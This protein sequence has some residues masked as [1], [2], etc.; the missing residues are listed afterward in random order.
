VRVARSR[1]RIFARSRV[2]NFFLRTSGVGRHAAA[3]GRISV[4]MPTPKP[5]SPAELDR[6]AAALASDAFPEAMPLDA[7]QGMFYALASGPA[8]FPSAD[9]WLPPLLGAD[10]RWPDGDVRRDIEMLLKRFAAE[11]ERDIRESD[12]TLPLLLFD[13]EHGDP[14]Y[15]TWCRGYLD[16]VDASDPAWDT[17]A[18]R[19]AV[20]EMLLSIE[21]LAQERPAAAP[22]RDDIDDL[23]AYAREARGDIVGTLL[24][25]RHFWFDR[26]TSR[27]PVTRGTPKVGRNDP[28]PCGSGRKFKQCHGSA[29]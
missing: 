5:L 10:V 21:V 22:A 9:A 8:D 24:D 12:D 17:L 28:C 20:D 2:W 6:L 26:R 18:D 1:A 13:D 14:D 27:V 7:A 19:D 25:I 29:D 4:A 16:G 15:E 23:R 11:C 3:C